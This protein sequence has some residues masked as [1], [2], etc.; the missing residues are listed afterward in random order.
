MRIYAGNMIYVPVGSSTEIVTDKSSGGSGPW[1]WLYG[2]GDINF[3]INS[4]QTGWI[5]SGSAK[6]KSRAEVKIYQEATFV[7]TIFIYN[8]GVLIAQGSS[9]IISN[10]VGDGTA[11]NPIETVSIPYSANI[12]PSDRSAKNLQVRL[13]ID[14]TGVKGG[15]GQVYIGPGVYYE[16][17]NALIKRLESNPYS[18]TVEELPPLIQT[19]VLGSITNDNKYNNQTGISASTNSVSV[20]WK[21][22]SGDAPTKCEYNIG[23]GWIQTSNLYSQTISNLSPGKSYTIQI[24]GSNAA[25]TSNTISITIRTRH[26]IPST[27]LSLKSRDLETLTFDWTSDKDLESTEYK[28]DTGNWTNLSQSGKSGSFTVKWFDPKTTHTIYFRGISTSAYDSLQS[29]EKSANGTTLDR[30]HITNIGDCIFGLN[31]PI[32][33]ESESSKPLSLQIWTTGNSRNPIFTFENISNKSFTYTFSPTQQQLDDMYKCY[34]NTNDIPIYFLLTTNGDNKNWNDTQQDKTLQ[35]TG[36]AK[37]AHIGI[38]NSPRRAQVFIGDENK[39]PRRSV[40]WVGV[41]D[42][43]RRCI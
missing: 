6:I 16:S 41:S 23:N 40:A 3:S 24:R 37:T 7:A 20:S 9:S 5:A 10:M 2:E 18:A 15:T 19:P 32:V 30:A 12:T 21:L 33:I 1:A 39:K 27:T 29:A 17:I 43:A 25:G 36:I 31:I 28:I 35:L 4:T 22:S 8:N 38:N 14:V 11:S 13:V 26:S 42:I 34:T